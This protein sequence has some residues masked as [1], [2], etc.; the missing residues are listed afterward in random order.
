MPRPR[1]QRP[2]DGGQQDDIDCWFRSSDD[3]RTGYARGNTF[4]L[5][6]VRYAVL[7]GLA[8]FEGD[9]VLGTVQQ[10]EYDA[11]TV[12]DPSRL[13]VDGVAITGDRYRWPGGVI[14]YAIDATLADPAIVEQAM[15]HWTERT[16]IRF[17][18]RQPTALEHRNYVSFETQNGCWSEVGM[19]GG[20]QTVSLG[21]GCGVGSAIHEIG[22]VV[23][24][25]HEQSRSDR[26]QYIDILWQNIQE[27]R[28]HNFNQQISD[29]DDIGVYDFGSIMHYPAVAF[30]KNNLPT[31]VTK[32]GEAI[33]QRIALSELDVAAVRALYPQ[34]PTT[35]TTTPGPAVGNLEGRSGSQILGAI[36]ALDCRRWITGDWPAEWNVIWNIVPSPP[37][38][39]VE[40]KVITERQSETLLRYYIE[41]RNLSAI[42]ANV[43]V[44]YLAL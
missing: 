14:P 7:D 42:E 12:S 17:V 38:A 15:A 39:R 31:I 3:V 9:I 24:L 44:R 36:S 2:A 32:H 29:G 16:S 4:D 25:W 11:S 10:L 43:E 6:R 28:E 27:G 26:D 20:K 21:S 18:A 23:G 13:P 41:V 19:R 35:T 8:L 22:H 30:S 40:W 34:D 1:S 5:K 33:G 37:S